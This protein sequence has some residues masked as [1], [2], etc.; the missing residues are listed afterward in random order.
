MAFTIDSTTMRSVGNAFRVSGTFESTTGVG[1]EDI[2]PN[3]YILSLSIDRNE[4]DHDTAIGMVRV[5]TSDHSG[6]ADNGSIAHKEE[7]ASQTIHWTADFT[8]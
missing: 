6:T 4:D 1:Q 5:N 8:M 7:T 3:G 2:F